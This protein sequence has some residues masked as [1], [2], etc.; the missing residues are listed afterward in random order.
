MRISS[1][2]PNSILLK[3][4]FKN[5]D[6]D[7]INSFKTWTYCYYFCKIKAKAQYPRLLHMP[8]ALLNSF[9]PLFIVM[10]LCLC[11]W[12][13]YKASYYFLVEFKTHRQVQNINIRIPIKFFFVLIIILQRGEK[14]WW[15]S[16]HSILFCGWFVYK[17]DIM[18]I[19]SSFFSFF[20]RKNAYFNWY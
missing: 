11:T 10:C 18:R 19:S 15:A 6:T 3:S 14:I 13:S 20:Y 8:K 2:V 17:K 16:W 12:E 9:T 1:F 7:L 4:S 5:R